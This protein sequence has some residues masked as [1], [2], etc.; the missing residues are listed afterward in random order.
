MTPSQNMIYK[1]LLMRARN[2]RDFAWDRFE[3]NGAAGAAA[4]AAAAAAIMD[5]YNRAC[6]LLDT[7]RQKPMCA[8]PAW[9][10][11]TSRGGVDWLLAACKSQ[12]HLVSQASSQC[13]T[14][15]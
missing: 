13:W 2:V 15:W 1:I 4:A 12:C 11:E 5:W 3:K 6:C 10:P 9:H 7:V 14:H 8:W